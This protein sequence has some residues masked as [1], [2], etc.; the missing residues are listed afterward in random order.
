MHIKYLPMAFTPLEI[1]GSYGQE[2]RIYS[3]ECQPLLHMHT[4][5]VDRG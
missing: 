2:G 1:I 3:M 5:Q 4:L